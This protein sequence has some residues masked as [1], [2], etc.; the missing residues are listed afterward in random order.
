MTTTLVL[1]GLIAGGV[2]GLSQTAGWPPTIDLQNPTPQSVNGRK[3]ERYTHGP[4]GE[5]GYPDSNAAEWA[6]HPPRETGA[7]LQNHNTFYVVSPTHP[8]DNLPLYVVLHSAN[9]TGYDYM[10][11]G[12]L[13]RKIDNND[14]PST[15]MTNVPDGFYGLYLSSTNAEWWGWSQ[16]H[17]NQTHGI[18]AAPPA[19]LRVLNTIEWVVAKYHIN[20]N[21]IYLSGVSMGGNGTLGIGMHHG[22]I[23]AAIR[24]I[25]PAGTNF[26]SYSMGQFAPSP[27]LDASAIARQAWID[28]VSSPGRPDPPVIVDFSS[29]ADGWSTTQSALVTATEY[30]RFP[31]VLAWGPFGHTA[32][33]SVI[34]K[35]PICQIALAF[36]WLEIRKNEAYPVFTKSTVDQRSPWLNAPAD[37][38]PAGQINAYLR[39]KNK[40]DSAIAFAIDLWIADPDVAAPQPM[41]VAATADVTLRRLQQFRPQP[42]HTYTWR[43]TRDGRTLASGTLTP[44]DC[45]LLTI[46]KVSLTTAPTELSIR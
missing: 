41:P 42:G 14:D 26:A 32:F 21:R 22:D 25:V 6:Y 18:D 13:D 7:A 31:L 3:I 5:W 19:E 43:L 37:F 24:A 34:A 11:Y 10:A 28:H 29:P 30:G 33:G 35:T 1:A 46:T 38:D 40:T 16:A 12:L 36:P 15:T 9:R 44:D 27:G 45:D 8:A 39:W 17:Q 20:R 23:F 4:R 2:L